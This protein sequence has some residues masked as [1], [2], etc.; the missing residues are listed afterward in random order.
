MREKTNG[1]SPEMFSSLRKVV[2]S[3]EGESKTLL[4][5]F[6]YDRW[7]TTNSDSRSYSNTFG[8]L[9][10]D[11]HEIHPPPYRTNPLRR[12]TEAK[13]VQQGEVIVLDLMGYGGVLRDLEV[14]GCAVALTDRRGFITRRFDR[15]LGI[16]H[17]VGDIGSARTWRAMENWLQ[18]QGEGLRFDIICC[19]PLDGLNNVPQNKEFYAYIFK[20]LYSMLSN[21]DGYLFAQFHSSMSHFVE[22]FVEQMRDIE[23]IEVKFLINPHVFMLIKH[24]DSPQELI[25]P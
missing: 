15:K 2:E 5:R 20:K 11:G 16:G 22:E 10:E 17:I 24:R 14:R 18:S 21:N 3:S 6:F 7:M 25:V 8:W 12:I 4:G 1:I 9:L 23:G 19:H 13:K